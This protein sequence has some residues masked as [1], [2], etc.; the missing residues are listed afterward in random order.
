MG[1]LVPTSSWSSSVIVEIQ[2]NKLANGILCFLKSRKNSWNN[3]YICNF[4][5]EARGTVGWALKRKSDI[6]KPQQ[7][8]TQ[9]KRKGLL[10]R[11]TSGFLICEMRIITCI[12]DWLW[13]SNEIKWLKAQ[14]ETVVM[15]QHGI[16]MFGSKFHPLIYKFFLNRHLALHPRWNS[17]SLATNTELANL[18]WTLESTQKDACCK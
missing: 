10:P 16:C 9:W 7:V 3:C 15:T 18:N 6:D 14:W 11:G 5:S 12:L 4:L 17:E 2:G 1:F 13:S 8:L